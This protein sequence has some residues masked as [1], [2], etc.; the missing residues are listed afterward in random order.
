MI[1]AVVPCAAGRFRILVIAREES[2]R[3]GFR[4]PDTDFAGIAERSRLSVA[5]QKLN[6][7]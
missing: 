6:L 5:G 7:V 4:G 1:E 2:A 3:N